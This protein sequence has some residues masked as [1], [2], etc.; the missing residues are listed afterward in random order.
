MAFPV[1]MTKDF[2]YP[3]QWLN[4]FKYLLAFQWHFFMETAAEMCLYEVMLFIVIIFSLELT[5]LSLPM[6]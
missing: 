5:F 1:I 2:S 4:P 6:K 3:G